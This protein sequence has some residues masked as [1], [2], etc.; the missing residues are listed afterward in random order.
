MGEHLRISEIAKKAGVLP[1]KIRYYTDMGLLQVA[2]QTTGGH[3]LYDEDITLKKLNHIGFLSKKGLSIDAIKQELVKTLQRKKVIVIDDEPEVAQLVEQVIKEKVDAEVWT[4]YDGFS[5][6]RLITEHLP[7]LIVLDIMLPGVN[8][9]EICKQIHNLPY[10][11]NT[12]ILA[13]TGYDSIENKQKIME[14]GANDYLAKPM[15]IHVLVEKVNGL[16]GIE[17]K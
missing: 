4:A 12:K 16:L 9:F 8:G 1:S 14:A 3:R 5:A 15:D 13:M 6:G 10:M 11:K 7:D 17:K 2:T